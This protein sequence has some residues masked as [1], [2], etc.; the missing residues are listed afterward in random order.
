MDINE[1]THK[2]SPTFLPYYANCLARESFEGLISRQRGHMSVED[3]D[4]WL[5]SKRIWIRKLHF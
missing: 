3:N 4:T 5:L 1:V 2:V